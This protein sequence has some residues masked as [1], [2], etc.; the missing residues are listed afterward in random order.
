MIPAGITAEHVRM[1]VRDFDARV[2]E[3]RFADSTRYDLLVEG[4]RYP[5]KAIVGLAA[6]YV[7][8][9]PLTPEDFSGGE[10]ST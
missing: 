5:P 8:G 7:T 6:R 9:Q 1:A 3:H 10:G 4:R 2:V